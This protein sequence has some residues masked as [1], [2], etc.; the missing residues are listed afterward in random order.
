MPSFCLKDSS[1]D[2]RHNSSVALI[3]L[4]YKLGIIDGDESA[5]ANFMLRIHALNML[6]RLEEDL[7]SSDADFTGAMIGLEDIIS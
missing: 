7:Y 4:L 5:L 1:V 2:L 3:N 6:K